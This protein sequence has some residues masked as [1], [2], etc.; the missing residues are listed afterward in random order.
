MNN[1]FKAVNFGDIPPIANAVGGFP[2]KFCDHTPYVILT[3]QDHYKTKYA[4]IDGAPVLCHTVDGEEYYSPISN[5]IAK[6]VK[7]LFDIEKKEAVTL[8]VISE[9]DVDVLKSSFD[10]S[11]IECNADWADYIYLHSDL[12]SFSGKRYSGQRNHINKFISAFPDWSYETIDCNNISDVLTFYLELTADTSSYDDTAIYE[13][14]KIIE[15]LKNN[16][17]E[18]L[19]LTGGLIRA[20]GN[21]VSF[22]FG[23]TINDMLFVHVEKARRDIQGA[24]QMIVREYASH[25]PAVFINREE[26]MGLEGLRTSKRSYHPIRLENKYKLKVCLK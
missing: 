13:R 18:K 24:Y 7:A 4:L 9:N 23:E 1:C 14:D 17:F 16:S 5:D 15:Y 19:G 8:S 6:T 2:T 22:A 11:E 26:D 21:V 10:T 20:S 3:W 12:A 25:N